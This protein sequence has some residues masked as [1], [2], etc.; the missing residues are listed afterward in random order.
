MPK[1]VLLYINKLLANSTPSISMY[2]LINVFYRFP[3]EKATYRLSNYIPLQAKDLHLAMASATGVGFKCPMGSEALEMYDPPS[4][5]Q[6]PP[7]TPHYPFI[8]LHD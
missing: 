4:P 2:P 8:L 5:P 6:N 3:L 7:R 1:D